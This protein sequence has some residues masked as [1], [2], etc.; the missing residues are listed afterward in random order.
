MAKLQAVIDRIRRTRE[1]T[2][3]LLADVEDDLWLIKPE[4]APTHIAWQ[5]GHIAMA[6]YAL[7]LMRVRESQ[8]GDREM[9]SREFRRQFSKGTTPDA[10][11]ENNPSPAEIRQ[12]F[13]TIYAQVMV[14]APRFDEAELA[15]E[16][17]APHE[18]FTTKLEA[19]NFSADHEWLHGG[20]IGLLR[21]M[22]GK[23]PVR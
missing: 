23:P 20:Q 9:M 17:A 8:P 5:V 21:R 11:K 2:R 18:M 4:G 12:V 6:Q 14:E 1:Y 10:D 19:L 3:T 15:Q 7:C 22:L 16:L 13:D